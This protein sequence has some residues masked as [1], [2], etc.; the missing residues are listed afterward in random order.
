MLLHA[1]DGCRVFQR[2]AVLSKSHQAWFAVEA[3]NMSPSC[4][5]E[6]GKGFDPGVF[7]RFDLAALLCLFACADRD[8]SA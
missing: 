7:G 4:S 2:S 6:L 5:D 8:I 3:V 1:V